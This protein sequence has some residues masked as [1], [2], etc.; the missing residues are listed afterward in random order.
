MQ[1]D[2]T[3]GADRLS[4]N[5]SVGA[6][7]PIAAVDMSRV[8]LPVF[9]I[10]VIAFLLVP[11]V[12]VAVMS[13]GTEKYLEFPPR[14]LSAR[15]YEA[16]FRDTEWVSATLFSLRVAVVTAIASTGIGTMAA[17]GLVRGRLPCRELVTAVV[18]APMAAPAIIVAIAIYLFFAPMHLVGTT[19]GFVL[20]HTVLT[21][22]YV[23]VTVS[24]ALSRFDPSLELAA[25]SLGAS[26]RKAVMKV[27]VPLILPGILAGAAFAFIT[28]FDEAV[29]SF[30]LS[31]VTTKTLPKKLFEDIDFDVSPIVAA[32][33][34]LL[35]GLSFVVMGGIELIRRRGAGG[36]RR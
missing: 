7:P 14:A 3:V 25:L 2:V 5:V 29:V 4:A 33:G 11:S 6:K 32:V 17:L 1:G 34:T 15:W 26:R 36:A 12:L 10:A 8:A 21:A 20:A 9:G 28:S 31:G 18:L 23:V 13:F 16:Y 30:F 22:P 24:A 27:T 35:T 19:T